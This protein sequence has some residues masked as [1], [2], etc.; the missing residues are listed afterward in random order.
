RDSERQKALDARGIADG[1]GGS[2]AQF[3]AQ[4]RMIAIAAATTHER[5]PVVVQG[6]DASGRWSQLSEGDDLLEVL[7]DGLVQLAHGRVV[8]AL[9]AAKDAPQSVVEASAIRSAEDSTELLDEL[10]GS[11]EL[12]VEAKELPEAGAL[13]VAL[14]F[15]GAQDEPARALAN[16]AHFGSSSEEDSPAQLGDGLTGPLDDVERV[17]DV[18]DVGQLWVFANRLLVRLVHV[19]GEQFDGGLL[20]GRE[21]VDP[22][23]ESLAAAAVPHPNGHTRREVADDGHELLLTLVPPSEPLVGDTDHGEGRPRRGLVPALD[24][25]EFGAAYRVPAQPPFGRN[26]N[27]RHRERVERQVV[28]Q[29]PGLS[30]VP[31]GPCQELDRVS[32]A[33]FAPQAVR[34]VLDDHRVA[35]GRQV[36]PAPHLELLMTGAP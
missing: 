9:G 22:A 24:G 7:L 25:T 17:M 1:V 30:V 15:P 12:A 18:R 32:A 6:L 4:V 2:E 28:L 10:V 8:A 3:G 26:V 29:A 19:G 36:R 34:A 23:L 33:A 31:I 21:R 13:L 5:L 14:S 27:Q 16:G 11:G 35:T 20:L